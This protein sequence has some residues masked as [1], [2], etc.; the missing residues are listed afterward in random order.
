MLMWLR[1]FRNKIDKKIFLYALLLMF[2]SVSCIIYFSFFTEIS[3]YSDFDISM[4]ELK[5]IDIAKVLLSNS[6]LIFFNIIFGLITFGVYNVASIIENVYSLSIISNILILEN[7]SFLLYRLIP[8]GIIEIFVLMLSFL[9]VI[10][11]WLYLFKFVK[12][13]LQRKADIRQRFI[14]IIEWLVVNI[15]IL[16][17]LLCVAAIVEYFVSI[18]L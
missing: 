13:V 3:K 18:Y 6:K 12:N 16:E 2:V 7:Q 8:Q 11:A 5:V 10:K 17:I 1:Y 15:I 9:I 4:I 14:F